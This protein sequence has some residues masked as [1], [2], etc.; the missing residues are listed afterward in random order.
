MIATST[1]Q[2][3]SLDSR[4]C[5]ALSTHSTFSIDQILIANKSAVESVSALLA[6]PCSGSPQSS[7]ILAL[8]IDKILE[9][10]RNIIQDDTHDRA[11]SVSP[12]S[13]TDSS[14]HTTPITLGSY[15]IDAEDEH[16]IRM[17]LVSNELR[18]AMVLVK[19][20][21]DKYL[22]AG[23]VKGDTGA[24]YAALAGFLKERV[25]EGS[26]EIVRALQSSSVKELMRSFHDGSF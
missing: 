10:Y 8:I 19:K 24:I 1:L 17:Q 15:R 21:A 3:I 5:S 4:S 7:I 6:C 18:K 20:Y 23:Q 14:R 13:S 26:D 22:T 9:R 11:S 25:H 2:S 16:C 12:A